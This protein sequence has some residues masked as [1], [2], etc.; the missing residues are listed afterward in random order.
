MFAR[1]T[2]KVLAAVGL[3][4]FT[5][6][7]FSPTVASADHRREQLA[8]AVHELH[9]AAAHFHEVIHDRT[10]YSRLGDIAHQ[11][12][13]EAGHLHEVVESGASY[14]H[15]SRDFATV[16]SLFVNPDRRLDYAHRVHHSGHVMRD[17]RLVE[18]A[19]MRVA[20]QLGT[21]LWGPSFGGHGA[22]HFDGGSP[23]R[24][25]QNGYR[26]NS[27]GY[28]NNGFS[29]D[30]GRGNSVVRLGPVRFRF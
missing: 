22:G 30:V 28:S 23:Y 1:K 21:S 7:I 15:V 14:E 8:L 9:E 27:N 26:R 13:N 11:L 18:N 20:R 19:G 6:M 2:S 29:Y 4:S 10:G 25:Q 12:A 3:L 24:N 17:W 5:A 16:R